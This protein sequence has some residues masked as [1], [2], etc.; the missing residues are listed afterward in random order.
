MNAY[1]GQVRKNEKNLRIQYKVTIYD[2][3][4]RKALMDRKTQSF[5]R[6]WRALAA[7]PL[8]RQGR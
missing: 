2:R 4:T 7:F 5:I 3:G 6:T 8:L 1:T